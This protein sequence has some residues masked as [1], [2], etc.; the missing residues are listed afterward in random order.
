[1]VLWEFPQ[2]LLVYIL[3]AAVCAA[4]RNSATKAKS[5]FALWAEVYC[6]VRKAEKEKASD[7]AGTEASWRFKALKNV[8]VNKAILNSS[9]DSYAE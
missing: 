5:W 1:M 7:T 6:G 8:T 2:S 3:P 9:Y 4:G